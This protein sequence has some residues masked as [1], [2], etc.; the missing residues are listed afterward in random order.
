MAGKTSYQAKSVARLSAVQALYQVESTEGS[1]DDAFK[2][3]STY[4][5][6]HQSHQALTAPDMDLFQKIV[7]GVLDRRSDID[8][9]IKS[10]LPPEWSFERLEAL[11]R[12]I[13][14]AACSELLSNMETHAKIILNEYVNITASYY[15]KKEINFVNGLLNKI[16]HAQRSDEF[17]SD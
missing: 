10:Y 7:L 17:D 6:P 8:T 14:Q 16:A 9:L 12:L 13:L 3:F 4:H 2:E 5:F 15:N 11:L 1:L